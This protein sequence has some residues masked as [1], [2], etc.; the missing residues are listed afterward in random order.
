MNTLYLVACSASKQT[1]L[2]PARD[3][4]RGGA[5][6]LSRALVEASGARWMI[7]SARYGAF[8]PELTIEPYN[9][10]LR[11][12]TPLERYKWAHRVLWQVS[13]WMQA[14]TGPPME[15]VVMLAPAL[16]CEHLAGFLETL[17]LKVETPL[18]GLMQGE[19][20]HWLKA[21]QPKKEAA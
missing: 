8:D 11:D 15:R 4:Y 1:G 5:F 16:Y 7:L 21:N 12:L 19:Q 14:R 10:T 3:L 20:L 18:K 13:A 6:K 9:K 2:R 17:G